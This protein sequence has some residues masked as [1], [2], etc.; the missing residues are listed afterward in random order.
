M[1]TGRKPARKKTDSARIYARHLKVGNG[2]EERGYLAGPMHGVNGHRTHAHQPCL[3]DYTDGALQCA[4][5]AAGLELQWRGYVPLWDRD[6]VLRYALV[7]QDVAESVDAIPHGQQ[8]KVTRAKNPISPLVIRAEQCLTRALPTHA[9]YS[10]PVDM[11]LICL[12]L[13]K[14]EQLDQWVLARRAKGAAG[15]RPA[16]KRSDGKEF[17]PMLRGAAKKYAAPSEPVDLEKDYE[18]VAARLRASAASKE[19]H[20]NGKHAKKE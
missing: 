16:P 14:C 12:T 19:P 5:C 3:A 6:W 15:E 8:V 13:W 20:A 9:P 7:G 10:A 1:A 17:T 11:E 4:Y 2:A 18:A